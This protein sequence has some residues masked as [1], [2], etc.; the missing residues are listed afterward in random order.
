MLVPDDAKPIIFQRLCD[1][2]DALTP[3]DLVIT[4]LDAVGDSRPVVARAHTISDE[5]RDRYRYI[6]KGFRL[7]TAQLF[8]RRRMEEW[9]PTVLDW[10]A[11]IVM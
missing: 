8:G 4:H 11:D 9:F 6:Y 7:L 10:D 5:T 2:D 3:P 1:L